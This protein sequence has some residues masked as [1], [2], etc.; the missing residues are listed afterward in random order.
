M[1]SA[2]APVIA[3]VIHS[4]EGGGTERMLVSLLRR[5]DPTRARH[6]VVTM[7]GAGSLAE[8]LPDHVAC[9]PL[10]ETGRSRFAFLRLAR[11]L[12][13]CHASVIHARNTGC[14]WDA[15]VAGRLT[16]CASTVLGFHGLETG[17]HFDPRRRRVARIGFHLGARF[18]SVSQAGAAQLD[19]QA[20]VP[21]NEIQVLPNGIDLHRFSPQHTERRREL[22]R[23]M[24]LDDGCVVVGTV[25]S[26]TPIKRHDLLIG[27]VAR[28]IRSVKHV[29]LLIVGDGATR[30]ACQNQA[31]AAGIADRVRFVGWRQDVPEMLGA[32][33]L[34]ACTSDS[35]GMNNALLEA[36]AVGV[37][38]LA[39]DV[40][41][42]GAMVRH[43]TEGLIVSPGQVDSVA[44]ALERLSNDRALRSRLGEACIRRASRFDIAV[45]AAS[46]ERYYSMLT[47]LPVV[48]QARDVAPTLH[49]RVLERS[50]SR[51]DT[52][53]VDVP[54][55][56]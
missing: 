31:I 20:S 7:R 47:G 17:S 14:W 56:F 35:E 49:T 39:T 12:R 3:H 29:H 13:A 5:F 34:Y 52:P 38:V 25:G 18:T 24:G 21:V 22:R 11:V 55:E 42:N 44:A 33:D 46:Y 48:K 50:E 32:M 37:P 10:G 41:D 36:M 2:H 4:L 8:E 45:A 9:R 23:A 51:V 43:E 30:T 1:P 28:V 40:G 16:P 27:A 15:I 19:T 26:L 53:L 54:G 6:V